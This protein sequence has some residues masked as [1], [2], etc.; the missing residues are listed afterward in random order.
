M[1]TLGERLRA[2]ID[3][4][5]EM[6]IANE[7]RA[8]AEKLAAERVRKEGIKSQLESY[9]R[10]ISDTLLEGLVFKPVKLPSSWFAPEGIG[11]PI[12]HAQHPDNHLWHDFEDWAE[13]EDLVVGYEYDHDGAGRES[14]Y[15]LT[16]KP[17]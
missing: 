14:W 2:N 15:N 4:M 3:L 10:E 6:R 12:F 11:R 8:N 7:N 13:G 5:E 16:V 17:L 1:P 9:K